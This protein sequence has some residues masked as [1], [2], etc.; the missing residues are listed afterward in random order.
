[1]VALGRSERGRMRG[2]DRALGMGLGERVLARWTAAFGVALAIA[3]PVA[4]GWG[5]GVDAGGGWLWIA[6]GAG[7]AAVASVASVTAAGR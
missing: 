6:A 7:V 3:F 4:V 2:L 1:V 5:I